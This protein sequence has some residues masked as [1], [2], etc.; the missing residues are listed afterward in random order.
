MARNPMDSLS[1]SLIIVAFK[2]HVDIAL[3]NAFAWSKN[4]GVVSAFPY[5]SALGLLGFNVL[6]VTEG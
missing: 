2:S 4:T 1:F 6:A 5:C 3:A